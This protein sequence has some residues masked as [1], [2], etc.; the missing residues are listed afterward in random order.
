[1]YGN[2]K[3]IFQC[4]PKRLQYKQGLCLGQGVPRMYHYTCVTWK[5]RNQDLELMSINILKC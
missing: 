2:I 5:V 4:K 1:M 3:H